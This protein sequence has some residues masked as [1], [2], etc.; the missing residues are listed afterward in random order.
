MPP[1]MPPAPRRALFQRVFSE[2]WG[3]KLLALGLAIALSSVVHSDTDAQRS[4]Y[5]DVVV[6]LPPPKSGRMLVSDVPAQVKV[7]LVGSESKLRSLS[8]DDFS[9]VQLDLRTGNPETYVIDPREISVRSG[10][11]VSA[12]SPSTIPLTW[13]VAAEKRVPVRVQV[14]G[15]LEKHTRL[16]GEY[17]VEPEYVTLR[18]PDERLKSIASVL[19][20]PIA[21]T[22]LG[23]GSHTR[24][25]PLERSPEHVTIVDAKSIVV[26]FVVVP[27]LAERALGRLAVAAL[28]DGRARLRPSRVSVVLR[29][30]EDVMKELSPEQV[31]PYVE[32]KPG[33]GTAMQSYDVRLRGLP[34]GAEVVRIAPSSVLARVEGK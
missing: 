14:V 17:E 5:L 7:T 2:N 29:G 8:R 34:E 21:L 31:V 12:V 10:V 13:A 26:R 24:K 27:L 20:E 18:G 4:I 23:L 33:G 15:S 28:G 9:P 11:Q 6:L 32:L 22:G 3:L 25:V 30:P 1:S 19:T 16:R